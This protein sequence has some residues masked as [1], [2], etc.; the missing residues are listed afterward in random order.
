MNDDNYKI[1]IARLTAE[2]RLWHKLDMTKEYFRNAI[3]QR[4]AGF[5]CERGTMRPFRVDMSNKDILVQM[6]LYIIAHPNCAW[7]VNKGLY[8]GGKVGCGKTI[9]MRI[10]I[11][12]LAEITGYYIEMVNA[13]QLGNLICKNGIEHYAKRPLFIDDLGRENLEESFYGRVMRPVE[14]LISYRYDYGARTF[15]TSNFKPETLGQGYDDKGR[16]VGYGNYILDRMKETVNFA[17]LKG[18]SRRA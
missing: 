7:D 13:R 5:I 3:Y 16:K 17:V 1:A 15:Y 10:F 12:L 8:L 11:S 6:Y 18:E 4:G 9:I 14:E 2:Q